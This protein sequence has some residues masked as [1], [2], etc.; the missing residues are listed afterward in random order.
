MYAHDAMSQG[1]AR[2]RELR[3]GLAK[4]G[5]AGR[6]SNLARRGIVSLPY[7]KIARFKEH[8]IVNSV[9]YQVKPLNAVQQLKSLIT[10]PEGF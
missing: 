9:N 4:S 6:A 3:R 8:N 5:Q 2:H 10:N 7:S 1:P